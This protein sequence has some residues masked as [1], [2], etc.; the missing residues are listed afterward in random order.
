M[1]TKEMPR[2]RCHKEVRALKIKQV[3]HN[4]SDG[5]CRLAFED[6]GY[7]PIAVNHMFML[8]HAPKAGG[9]YVLCQDGYASWSPAEAFEAGYTRLI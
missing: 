1:D 6:E 8:K 2:Y 7:D 9:Y 4:E 3:I 5:S